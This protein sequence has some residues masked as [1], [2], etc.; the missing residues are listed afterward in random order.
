MNKLGKFFQSNAFTILVV[1]LL[2]EIV[3]NPV[4][5]FSLNDD[6]SYAKSVETLSLQGTY[7]IGFWPAMTLI[8]HVLWG[9]LFTKVFGFSFTVL[10][11]SVTILSFIALLV[12]EK[13]V[14]NLSGNKRTSLFA[15]LLLLVNPLFFSLSNTFMTDASFL[16]FCVFSLYFYERFFSTD[17]NKYLFPAFLMSLLALFTRQLAIVIPA[18]F[19]MVAFGQMLFKKQNRFFP[20][21][22]SVAALACSI[23]LLYFYEKWIFKTMVDWASYQGVFFSKRKLEFSWPSFYDALESRTGLCLLYAGLCLFPVVL[24]RTFVILKAFVRSKIWPAIL[25]L[26]IALYTVY[27][28][29]GLFPFGN[30]LYNCGLG[31]ETTIDTLQL[32]TNQV[33]AKSGLFVLVLKI[34]A[35]SGLVLLMLRTFSIGRF[36][37]LQRFKGAESPFPLFVGL[38]LAFYTV[39]VCVSSSFF[40]RYALFFSFCWMLLFFIQSRSDRPVRSVN[41]IPLVAVGLFSVFATKDYFNYNRKKEEAIDY[42]K[43]VEMVSPEKIHGGFE[44]FMWNYYKDGVGYPMW[45]SKNSDYLV[46]FGPVEHYHAIANF[47]YHRYIPSKKDTIFVLEKNAP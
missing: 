3:A 17:Q 28:V 26:G 5:E 8:S 47:P 34:V 23:G 10:R 4:G 31:I 40:D 14:F 18:V 29:I 36:V 24:F 43:K 15:A 16:A 38:V 21:V 39:V 13:L 32:Q 1:F 2:M 22:F 44:Y 42:L 6:W 41:Y 30:V 20:F 46:S 33:H 45:D 7:D 9:F 19:A 12:T 25:C 35:V 37:L 27:L 11:L